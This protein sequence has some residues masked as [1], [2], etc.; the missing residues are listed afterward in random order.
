[1]GGFIVLEVV[2]PEETRDKGVLACA[3]HTDYG[4]VDVFDLLIGCHDGGM[5][6]FAVSAL[7][8]CRAIATGWKCLKQLEWRM[9]KCRGTRTSCIFLRTEKCGLSNRI[10]GLFLVHGLL[11]PNQVGQQACEPHPEVSCG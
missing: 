9:E 8:R 6:W 3:R 11:S 4:D 7:T 2:V 1:V 5:C 10:V